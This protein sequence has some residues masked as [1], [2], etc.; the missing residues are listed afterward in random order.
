MR[1]TIWNAYLITW[2]AYLITWNA[3]LAIWN[4]LGYPNHTN[5]KKTLTRNWGSVFSGWQCGISNIDI[6]RYFS[7]VKL[8]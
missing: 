3:Y 4:A 6:E 2:N 8:F 5:R 1:L 7:T